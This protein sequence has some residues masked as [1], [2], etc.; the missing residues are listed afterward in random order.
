MKKRGFLT[1]CT[2]CL[3]GIFLTAIFNCSFVLNITKPVGLSYVDASHVYFILNHLV[4]TLPSG[5]WKEVSTL[6]MLYGTPN[7]L[8]FTDHH[9]FL[10][11]IILP[12]YLLTKNIIVSTNLLMLATVFFSFI[13]MY[14]LAFY[15]TKKTLPSILAAV[16]YVFNPYV[17]NWVPNYILLFSIQWIPLII[18]FFEKSIKSPSNK[19]TFLFFLFLVLQLLASSL[20]YSAFLTVILPVYIGIRLWQEKKPPLK[21]VNLGT[22]IGLSLFVFVSS[23]DAYPYLQVFSKEPI[24]RSFLKTEFYY[25]AWISNWFFTSPG[26][27]LYGDLRERVTKKAVFLFPYRSYEQSLFWGVIPFIIFLISFKVIKK[28]SY[29][30]L[31]SCLLAILIFSFLL[32]F[33][34]KIHITDKLVFPG[35]YSLIY[36]VNPLFAYLRVPAR[37][38]LFVFFSLA[39]ITAMTLEKVY[40][41]EKPQKA[42]LLATALIVLILLEYWNRPLKFAQITPQ[43]KKFYAILNNQKDI[44][45]ILDLPI[46]KDAYYLFWAATLH[47]K[48]L[49]NGYSS[50]LP[51]E[52][53]RKAVLISID[54]PTAA[55]L[56]LL[57]KWKVDGIVLHRNEFNKQE[58]F[59]KI[60]EELLKLNVPMIAA[61]DNL[62]L[63]DLDL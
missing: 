17:T 51:E 40:Q 43:T 36:K 24:N 41:K 52:Y 8:F 27:L 11:I 56:A 38:A 21:L 62:A 19:N 54:F 2:A 32:S 28:S 61:T 29:R 26:N 47:S 39:I 33:G 5:N 13:S 59:Y 48:K 50:F 6:P 34:P 20:Y 45:M 23:L 15:F 16:I 22:I 7:S 42:C 31:W 49:F 53:D 57:K 25:S 37:F 14:I 3:V 4:K 63:F 30:K 58:E 9:L 12:L 1:A 35:P 44:Q 46:A 18:L 10:G 55:K 60:K